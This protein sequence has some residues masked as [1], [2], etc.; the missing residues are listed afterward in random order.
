DRVYQFRRQNAGVYAKMNPHSRG[1]KTIG[2]DLFISNNITV[3]SWNL[4]GQN[5]VYPPPMP[6]N[7]LKK[8]SG[9]GT[10]VFSVGESSRGA[11]F[12]NSS[13]LVISSIWLSACC[14]SI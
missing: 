7:T 2:L 14:W 6:I 11:S 13:L 8:V 3:F 10:Y 4:S 5:A 12:L 9:S 1:L